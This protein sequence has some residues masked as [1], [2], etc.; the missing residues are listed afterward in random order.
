MDLQNKKTAFLLL[1][2]CCFVGLLQGQSNSNNPFSMYGLGEVD[3]NEYGRSAG[4][5]G[6]GIAMNQQNTLNFSNPASLTNV[7]SM[8]MIF[9]F[10]MM[11]KNSNYSTSSS[12]LNSNNINYKRLALTFRCLPGW[13]SSFGIAPYSNVGYN[14]VTQQSVEGT[15]Q[16]NDIE[17]IGKGGLNKL[18]WINSFALGK[19][20]SFGVNSSLIFGSI[21]QTETN[22]SWTISN[23]NHIS[24]VYFDFGMQFHHSLSTNYAIG[25]G[26]IYGYKSKINMT[27]DLVLSNSSSVLKTETSTQT[28]YLPQ[29]YGA[30][31]SLCRSEV[32][33][34]AAD[35]KFTGWSD[36]KSNSSNITFADVHRVAMGLDYSPNRRVV[37]SYF[38]RISFQL[39]AS[40]SNSMLK[41][42]GS[43]PYNIGY[44]CGIGFP[45]VNGS[46]IN[47]AYEYGNAGG[48]N[49]GLILEKYHQI[50]LNLSLTE[51]W[52]MRRKFN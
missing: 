6:V 44:S 47:I 39:G 29:F 41:R 37:M 31:I 28:Q 46:R 24:K 26:A 2:T 19:H 14:T 5:G 16:V 8:K 17:F 34:L 23:N 10:S 1:F 51:P 43:N 7:D 22:S 13:G 33:T 50:S 52:F 32:L 20:L 40:A 48:K 30:G 18:F 9:D 45:F 27:N 3:Q 38:D 11:A 12:S 49:A 15:L 25:L 42:N 35:Y 36:V 4:M 21:A